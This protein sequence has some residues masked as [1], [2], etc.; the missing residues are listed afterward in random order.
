MVLM[1]LKVE[2]GTKQRKAQQKLASKKTNSTKS[3]QEFVTRRVLAGFRFNPGHDIPPIDQIPWNK[4]QLVSMHK[5]IT[6]T[7]HLKASEIANSL[8]TQ[9][10]GSSRVFSS[11]AFF[12]IKI[13]SIRAWAITGNSL[14][15][16]I[17][18][19]SSNVDVTTETATEEVLAEIIDNKTDVVPAIGYMV[20]EAL[21][22]VVITNAI[23]KPQ[24][25]CSF[26]AS[27][28]S[29]VMVLFN[30]S[31]KPNGPQKLLYT[32]PSIMNSLR[33]IRSESSSI[34]NSMDAM[35]HT[36]HPQTNAIQVAPSLLQDNLP[37]FNT[38]VANP[39]TKPVPVIRPILDRIENLDLKIENLTSLINK[40]DFMSYRAGVATPD[41]EFE[42]LKPMQ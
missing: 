24:I 18:D 38:Y 12:D 10:D 30:L 19:W 17:Y 32:G 36:I 33:K 40:V 8:I 5:G 22:H 16:T 11:K 29:D 23:S 34:R 25:V 21:K 31:W 39:L 9:L 3:R 14:A 27:S 6:D 26:L 20:P 2:L 37:A 4:I 42:E 13:T 35:A 1:P 41:S 7:T 28:G 15:M